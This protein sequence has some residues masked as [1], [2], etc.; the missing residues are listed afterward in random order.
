MG[1]ILVKGALNDLE[2]TVFKNM[3]IIKKLA[4]KINF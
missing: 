1:T 3:S 4:T 2:N